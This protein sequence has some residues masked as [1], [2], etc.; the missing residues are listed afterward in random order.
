M[1]PE[2]I[3]KFGGRWFEPTIWHRV[4]S[5]HL[6]AWRGLA[7]K[8][9]RGSLTHRES[10]AS[11]NNCG[12]VRGAAMLRFR[13]KAAEEVRAMLVGETELRGQKYNFTLHRTPGRLRVCLRPASC[14][15]G[16]DEMSRYIGIQPF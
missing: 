12:T 3:C 4:Q 8:S 14:R 9:Q 11:Q 1:K 7:L 6:R 16:A 15:P 13:R 5:H 10:H 2:A